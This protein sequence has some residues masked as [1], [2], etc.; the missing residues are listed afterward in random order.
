MMRELADH[1]LDIAQN[2]IS[3]GAHLVTILVTCDVKSDLLSLTFTDDGCGMTPEFVKTVTD[4]FTTTRTTR[5]VGLGLP[6]LLQAA[7]MSGGQMRIESEPGKGTRVFAS[8]GLNHLDRPP[9]GDLAGTLFTLVFL[10]ETVD[11]LFV[12]V[13][14]GG[15]YEFDTREIRQAVEPLALNNPE[16]AGWIRGHLAES[17]QTLFGGVTVL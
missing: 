4:P 13:C 14:D 16:V 9:M 6:M 11:F 3:A 17:T 1:V 12:L 7:A 2:S 10:N 8:F 5:K 15:R